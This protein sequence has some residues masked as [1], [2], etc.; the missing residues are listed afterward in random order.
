MAIRSLSE[1]RRT[2]AGWLLLS[3]ALLTVALFAITPILVIA[4]ISMAKADVFGGVTGAFTVDNYVAL[5]DPVYGKTLGYSLGLAALTSIFCLILGYAVSHY[6]VSRP[7]DRQPLLLLLLIIPFWTDF[8][9]RTFAWISLL[10]RGG[11]VLGLLDLFGVHANSLVPSQTAVVLAMIYS[12]LPTAV[13]PIY[14]AMRGIDPSVRE[15]ASDLGAGWWQTH[16]RIVAPLSLPGI[17]AAFLLTF[18]PSLGVFVIPVLLGGGKD[19]LVGN[20]IVTLY[21]E[22]RNQPMGAALSMILLGLMLLSL[23]VAAVVLRT[24]ARRTA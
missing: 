22:F 3:P 6:I 15:A 2:L 23:L 1:R 20:L 8:L 5:I 12:F 7:A 17:I 4:R 21:T 16:L 14:A 24:R 18:V 13:F 19:L 10:G 9:V 11:P